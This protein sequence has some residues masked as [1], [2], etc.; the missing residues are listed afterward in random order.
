M[1]RGWY[2]RIRQL[3]KAQDRVGDQITVVALA[4][5]LAMIGVV[6]LA[7]VAVS[8]AHRGDHLTAAQGRMLSP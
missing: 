6:G 1:H 8:P 7:S 3:S 2:S 5:I 4:V